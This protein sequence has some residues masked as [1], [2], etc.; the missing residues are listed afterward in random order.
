MKQLSYTCGV[1][2]IA[3]M[4]VAIWLPHEWGKSLTSALLLI[5]LSAIYSGA[6]ETRKEVGNESHQDSGQ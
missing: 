3:F 5:V 4:I 6:A 1:G 2:A